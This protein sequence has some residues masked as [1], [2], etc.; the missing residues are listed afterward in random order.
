MKVFKFGG[1]SVKDPKGV[2][3]VAAILHSFPPQPLVI[4][5]SAM[6]K[7]T[8]ALEKIL[9]LFKA[10]Q[11]HRPELASLVKYHTDIIDAL[12][13]ADNTVK[14]EVQK[15]FDTLEDAL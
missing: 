9:S 8:N 10:G 5:I 4:V 14:S 11:N 1:A 3:N 15:I 12:F 6:G 7:T 13:S 2:K